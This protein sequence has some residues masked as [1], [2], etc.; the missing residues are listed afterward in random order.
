[1]RSSEANVILRGGPARDLPEQERIRRVEDVTVRIK[2]MR[3][4]RYEHFEPSTDRVS[5]EGHEL[6]AFDWAGSTYVA[7]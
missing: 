7:E 3:S 5:V 2:L 4:N 6:L 1:M